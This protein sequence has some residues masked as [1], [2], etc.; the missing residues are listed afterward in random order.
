MANILNIASLLLLDHS[1]AKFVP[2]DVADEERN[3]RDLSS[4]YERQPS[5]YLVIAPQPMSWRIRSRPVRIEK[6][7]SVSLFSMHIL[8]ARV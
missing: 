4:Y 3:G 8:V 2:V 1:F 6:A 7:V 5:T